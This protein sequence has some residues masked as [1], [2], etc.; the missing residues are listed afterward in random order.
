[1]FTMDFGKSGD[2]SLAIC[3]KLEDS[4]LNS[5]RKAL[6]DSV[7]LRACKECN[8]SFRNR[9]ITPTVVVLHLIMSAIWTEDSFNANWQILWSSAA[10]N[11]P[12]IAGKCPARGSVSVARNRLPLAVMDKVFSWLSE[13]CQK[14]SEPFDKWRGHRVVLVDGTC[15][16]MSNNKELH[17][18]FGTHVS[19]NKETRYPLARVVTLCLANTMTVLAYAVGMYE[20]DENKLLRPLLAKCHEGDI[21]IGD[22]HFAGANLYWHYKNNGL[23]FLT[24]IH[25]ALQIHRIKPVKTHA[26]NDFLG[27]M[28]IGNTYRKRVPEMPGE[29]LVRFICV[30]FKFRKKKRDLWFVTSLLD[31]QKY[32]ADEVVGLY[33][34]RWRIETLFK[35]LKV[36][37]HGDILRSQKADGI[38]REIAGRFAA[39]NAIRGIMLE[40]AI[41]QGIADPIRISFSEAARTIIAIAP[42]LA[43]HPIAELPIIYKAMLREIASHLVP[44]RPYR[45]EPR[46]LSRDPKLYSKLNE[47]RKQ[48]RKNYAAA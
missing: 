43:S 1:M 34:N 47:T 22:R 17:E 32:P 45:L 8:Y 31:A 13:H 20:R 40:A 25:Q 5:I 27:Y 11:H 7:I 35:E 2:K 4:V 26:K 21:L 42:A 18:K 15:M 24:R 48:W 6:P 28:K 29:I 38:Y 39:I 46:K 30:R 10:G 3:K 12:E 37:C 44:W 33:A 14:L 36:N 9:I 16:S 19:R 41:E 23:E